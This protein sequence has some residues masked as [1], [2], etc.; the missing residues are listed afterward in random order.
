VNFLYDMAKKTGVFSWISQD[1]LDQ[2]LQSFHHIKALW[3]QMIELYPVFRFLKGRWHGNQLTLGKCHERWL[4]SHAFFAQSLENELQYH[5][6]NMRINSGEDVATSCNKKLCYCRGT[7]L[8]ACQYKSC[9]YKTS[10]LKMIAIDKWPWSLY[11]W[12]HRN[13]CFYVGRI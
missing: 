4:I 12:G 11:A 9:N 13:C 6:L 2:F 10:H 7:A 5:C 3:E 8:R 1:I